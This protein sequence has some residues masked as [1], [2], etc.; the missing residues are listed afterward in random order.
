MTSSSTDKSKKPGGIR[1]TMASLFRSPAS[2]N[3]NKVLAGAS[4]KTKP[5][6]LSVSSGREQ[7][8]MSDKEKAKALVEKRDAASPSGSFVLGTYKP[9]S[10]SQGYGE[11]YTAKG[12]MGK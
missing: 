2:D 12:A 3:F 4:N 6:D 8:N 10:S 7:A 5:D 1:G 11:Y 9:L